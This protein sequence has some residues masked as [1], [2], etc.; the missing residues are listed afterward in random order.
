[1]LFILWVKNFGVTFLSLFFDK[2]R[3][4]RTEFFLSITY[5]LKVWHKGRTE[6]Y[7]RVA[8]STNPGV[9]EL[10]VKEI[11]FAKLCVLIYFETKK[12]LF[13]AFKWQN[14]SEIKILFNVQQ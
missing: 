8:E 6:V 4:L 11:N 1:M 5:C 7:F 2:R 10:K 9:K 12:N 3:F 14:I 13:P